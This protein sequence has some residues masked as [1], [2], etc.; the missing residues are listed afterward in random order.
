MTNLFF[1][2][3]TYQ[4]IIEITNKTFEIINACT[5]NDPRYKYFTAANID[6][7]KRKLYATNGKAMAVMPIGCDVQS[8]YYVATKCKKEYF[9]VPYQI[10]AVF[11][12][13]EKV[14]PDY[15]QLPDLI[16]K[17]QYFGENQEKNSKFLF[18]LLDQIKAPINLDFLKPLRYIGPFNV[19]YEEKKP[20]LFYNEHIQYIVMPMLSEVK[21]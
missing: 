15:S 20:I 21:R 2:G 12:K 7:S 5:S 16:V 4:G 14:I 6:T 8:G 13:A 19:K 9:L 1:T 3:K 10:D 11:P 18:T 17:A